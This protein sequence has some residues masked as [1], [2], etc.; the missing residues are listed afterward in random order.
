MGK[1]TKGPDYWEPNFLLALNE[2]E[3]LKPSKE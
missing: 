2:A 3:V 1:V